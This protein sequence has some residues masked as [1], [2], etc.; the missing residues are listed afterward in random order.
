MKWN[1]VRVLATL[2]LA[3]APG[4]ASP[5]FV[6]NFSF[7]NAPFGTAGSCGTGCT[8][9]VGTIPDWTQTGGGAVGRLQSGTGV[10]FTSLSDGPTTAFVATNTISQ[11]V[12]TVHIGEVYT[13]LVDIGNRSDRPFLGTADLLINGIPYAAGGST[14]AEGTFNTWRATYT[15]L[16]ADD[17]KS[18]TIQLNASGDQGNFDN[19][20]L[21]GTV[22][23]PA[24]FLLIGPALLVLGALRRRRPNA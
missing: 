17:G 22:P 21:D 20:R 11:T 16:A 12:G 15:G 4:F 19:V 18:I 8:K 23:E 1:A 24:S 14:P 9:F 6:A 2:A 5:I 13:L 7:E 3:A 10:F